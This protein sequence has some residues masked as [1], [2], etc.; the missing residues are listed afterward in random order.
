MN[1]VL[2]TATIY[3]H[4]LCLHQKSPERCAYSSNIDEKCVVAVDRVELVVRHRGVVRVFKEVDELPLLCDW[5]KDV[6][7]GP[8]DERRASD[9][10]NSVSQRQV[11][12]GHIEHVLQ[13]ATRGAP[14]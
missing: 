13:R 12:V 14:H 2:S 3:G 6:R 11:T 4:R 10:C 7:G 1:A 8:H 5:K 9:L